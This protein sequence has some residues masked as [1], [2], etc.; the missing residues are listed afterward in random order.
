MSQELKG[1]SIHD[2][3]MNL[4][5]VSLPAPNVAAIFDSKH[6]ALCAFKALNMGGEVAKYKIDPSFFKR[7]PSFMMVI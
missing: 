5:A 4:P 1:V 7:H 6:L 3:A 2:E